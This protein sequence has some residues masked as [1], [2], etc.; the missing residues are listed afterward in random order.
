MLDQIALIVVAVENRELLRKF[1]FEYALGEE[2]V[3]CMGGDGS[4]SVMVWH[5]CLLDS[6]LYKL[7][8]ILDTDAVFLRG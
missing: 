4:E 5:S 3:G 1:T 2:R 7:V 6:L 8:E